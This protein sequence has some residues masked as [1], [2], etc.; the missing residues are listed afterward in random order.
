MLQWVIREEPRPATSVLHP[1]AQ[2]N[3]VPTRVNRTFKIG[4]LNCNGLNELTKRQDIKQYM[5][6]N[7]ISIMALQETRIKEAATEN[8]QDYVTY[9]LSDPTQHITRN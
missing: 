4:T 5:T 6:Q 7:A 3:S 2:D 8:G 9:L 1:P